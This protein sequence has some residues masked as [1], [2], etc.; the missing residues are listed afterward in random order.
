MF[1]IILI[2]YFF[3]N[4]YLQDKV[5]GLNFPG[6]LTSNL[7]GDEHLSFNTYNNN[8]CTYTRSKNEE[9]MKTSNITRIGLKMRNLLKYK[10]KVDYIP[11][12]NEC[13]GD[14]KFTL[15]LRTIFKDT[16]YHRL[17]WALHDDQQLPRIYEVFQFW[18]YIYMIRPSNIHGSN[19]NLFYV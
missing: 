16:F 6:S 4:E 13:D 1:Y 17:Y 5:L 14:D 19:M 15:N 12:E 9:V 7:D 10:G 11:Y 3:L 2:I 18:G 8:I